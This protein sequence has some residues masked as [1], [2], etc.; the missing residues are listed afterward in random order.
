MALFMLGLLLP[1]GFSMESSMLLLFLIVSIWRLT[2]WLFESQQACIDPI[3]ESGL[4]GDLWRLHRRFDNHIGSLRKLVVVADLGFKGK[5]RAELRKVVS[6]VELVDDHNGGSFG[7]FSSSFLINFLLPL[8]CCL[9]VVLH[10]F[11]GS[12]LS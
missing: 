5:L 8:L 10:C 1:V 3:V 7:D 4:D 9:R 11:G 12:L 6:R 2:V